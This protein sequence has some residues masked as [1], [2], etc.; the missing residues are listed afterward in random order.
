METGATEA[1]RNGPAEDA[2][3]QQSLPVSRLLFLIGRHLTTSNDT[4]FR[5]P[6]DIKVLLRVCSALC[7]EQS[8]TL[9]T[10]NQRTATVEVPRVVRRDGTLRVCKIQ[11]EINIMISDKRK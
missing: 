2:Q 5:V 8:E 7:S 1:L 9:V 11:A 4:V 3:T 10:E 6:A